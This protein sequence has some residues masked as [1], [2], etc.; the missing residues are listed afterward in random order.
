MDEDVNLH[1]RWYCLNPKKGIPIAIRYLSDTEFDLERHMQAICYL[2]Y[3]LLDET[4]KEKNYICNKLNLASSFL[5]EKIKEEK[6]KENIG[7]LY[8]WKCSNNILLAYIKKLLYSCF[9][10][11]IIKHHPNQITN[12]LRAGAI[13]YCVEKNENQKL[14]IKDE[15]KIMHN[16]I[17]ENNK[18]SHLYPERY[19]FFTNNIEK[20]M[21]IVNE[22][23]NLQKIK[24][25]MFLIN[26][27][28]KYFYKV[29]FL[30][31]H[32]CYEHP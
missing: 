13:L 12:V 11:N 3:R 24:K 31:N 7:I 32:P 6:N 23:I 28:E 29:I 4:Y 25:E 17:F 5:E 8:R 27:P 22:P 26:N 1:Y 20:A 19:E 2:G 9:D 15:M 21:C 16:Y 30:I 14:K 10:F 18:F